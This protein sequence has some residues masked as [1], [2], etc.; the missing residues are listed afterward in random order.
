MKNRAVL[1]FFLIYF[2]FTITSNFVHPITPAFLQMIEAPSYIQGV[3]FSV[4]SFF[5][6]LTAPF[7]GKMGDRKP[8]P[9]MIAFGYF[10]YALGQTVFAAARSVPML[11]AARTISG[12]LNGALQV[13]ALAYLISVSDSESRG[14]YMAYYA[15]LQSVGTCIGYFVGGSIGDYS[16]MLVF[17][18]Q[19]ASVLF[20]GVISPIVLRDAPGRQLETGRI[21]YQEINPVASMFTS[22]KKVDAAM[23][24]YLA[25]VFCFGFAMMA[26]DN[27][28]SYFLRD[29][30][31]LPPPR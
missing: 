30:L 20:L 28:F 31:G 27:Y 13:N 10:G 17:Y 21:N 12:L 9:K 19:I 3:A 6:F 22:M 26:Y 5:T 23:G 25:T 14:K 16:L 15:M 18:I 11:L 2:G 29:Q 8:Y 1:K 7:W 4:M 24:V